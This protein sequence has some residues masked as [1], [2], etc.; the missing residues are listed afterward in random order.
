MDSAWHNLMLV[1][2]G[3]IYGP[4]EVYIDLTAIT[5]LPDTT[6]NSTTSTVS[7]AL[8]ME[9]IGGASEI[10]LGGFGGKGQTKHITGGVSVWRVVGAPSVP[11]TC[12]VQV[13]PSHCWG[14]MA[15]VHT[16]LK[17]CGDSVT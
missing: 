12:E 1:Q 16:G 2:S 3:T 11:T 13:R 5:L 4:G 15:A 9:D 8:W 7:R 17:H 6:Y 10:A 14:G